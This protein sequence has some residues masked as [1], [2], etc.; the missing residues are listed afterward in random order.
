MNPDRSHSG[1]IPVAIPPLDPLMASGVHAVPSTSTTS[2][3]ALACRMADMPPS[4]VRE[5]LKVAERPDIL[6]FA[7]GL[8]AP[9]LF[10]VEAIAQ[11]HAEVLRD[12]GAAA[13][14]YS[15]T[16]GFAPLRAWIAEHLHRRDIPARPEEI[17]ITS[18]SQQGIDLV[19]RVFL[20]PGDVVLVENPT[21]LAAIQA[22]AAYQVRLIAVPSDENGMQVDEVADLIAAYRPKLIYL[23]PSFQNPSG[24]TLSQERRARLAEI[25]AQNRV[26][27]LEDDPYGELSFTGAPPRPIAAAGHGNVLYVSTFS[28]TLAPGLRIGWLWGDHGIVRKATIAKQ[29]ADLH[30]ATLAQRATAALLARFDYDGHVARIREVYHERCQTMLTALAEHMPDGCRWI[31]PTGGMFVWMRLPEELD[32]ESL[33]RAAIPRKVAF[34]PGASF[35]V[36]NVRRNYVRLNFSN[37]PPLSIVEG[38]RRFGEVISDALAG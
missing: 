29:A 14:Q 37:Q 31:A 13:L 25:A 22:F 4:A 21:Y 19:A 34:V 32:A 2:L 5:I 16:E 10:P 35:F 23:V 33:L 28:K 6:S 11:A 24:T 38:M 36:D 9:E 17:L 30:T 12:A 7:G 1:L 15:T 18:G 8:P 27:I 3:P 20:D 26:A